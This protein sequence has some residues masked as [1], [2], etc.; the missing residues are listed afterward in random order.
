[1]TTGRIRTIKPEWLTDERLAMASDAARTLSIGLL[2]LADDHGNGRANKV[3]LA[4]TVFPRKVL[5]VGAK[6]VETLDEALGE[7]L[8]WF[9]VLYE[10][11]NQHYFH[12]VNWLKHQKVDKPGKPRVPLYSKPSETLANPLEGSEKIPASRG[13]YPG[14]G[15]GPGQGPGT[16]PGQLGSDDA[17]GE[18]GVF[19]ASEPPTLASRAAHW[20]DDRPAAR[21][22]AAFS[23]PHPE[24][25]PEVVALERA[26]AQAFGRNPDEFR[27]ATDERVLA[28]LA[29][30][31]EGYTPEQLEQAVRGAARDADYRKNPQWQNLG[32]ILK[33]A[34]NVDRFIALHEAPEAERRVP[35]RTAGD[36][37]ADQKRRL[38]EA[39]AAEA[40]AAAGGAR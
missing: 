39:Q 4:A 36:P 22:T 28:P 35:V 11:D 26:K 13:S 17:P 31:A 2:L 24:K 5:E 3:Q 7:L 8:G 19:E 10:V 14:P 21:Q 33:S 37:F 9:V 40:L 6:V 27:T 34:K 25:W 32:T 12:I 29:R 18:S 23:A 20:L 38:A 1:M 16:D 30:F 15:T